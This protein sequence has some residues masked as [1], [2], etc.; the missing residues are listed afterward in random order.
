MAID[1]SS[2]QKRL[3]RILRASIWGVALLALDILPAYAANMCN[4]LLAVD[5]VGGPAFALP[6]GTVR[7]RITLGT[8][9]V[10]PG[11]QATINRVRFGLDCNAAAA[12]GIPC[13]DEGSIAA[14]GGDGTITT[15][16]G[17]AFGTGHAA[18]A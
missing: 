17:V 18:G 12:L 8:A 13:T 6:G 14:Y 16:C 11:V 10:L 3:R 1:S 4:V 2:R 5:R 7:V 9:T 15:T